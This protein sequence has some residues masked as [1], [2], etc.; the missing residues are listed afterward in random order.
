MKLQYT[1]TENEMQPR[2]KWTRDE[3]AKKVHQFK[4]DRGEVS[5]RQFAQQ[6]NIARTTLQH[7]LSRQSRM[8]AS[9]EAITFFESPAGVAFLHRL[10][11]A[12]HLMM[13]LVNPCGIEQVGTF[14]DLAGLGEF[15][16]TSYSA[17]Y[18]YSK[19][20]LK[21]LDTYD[22]EQRIELV[23]RL[24]DELKR[25]G[26]KAK[27]IILLEDETFHPEICL[28]A[29]EAASNFILVETYS[30]RRDAESWNDAV[31]LGLSGLPV[32]VVA[33]NADEGKGLK[34][35]IEKGLGVTHLC[36]LFHVQHEISKGTSATL[37]Q[38]T[39]AASDSLKKCQEAEDKLKKKKK[40]AKSE[41]VTSKLELQLREAACNVKN[42]QAH[43]QEMSHQQEEMREAVR[44]LSNS[45]HPYDLENGVK[46]SALQVQK[47]LE[48]C[49]DKAQR[50][51]DEA[52]LSQR[53]CKHIEK[54]KRL[55]EA[56][57]ATIA[58][59][60]TFV[61]NR[62]ASLNLDT[63]ISDCLNHILIPLN[64][65]YACARKATTADR[66]NMI[67][68]TIDEL[69]ERLAGVS[70]WQTL[71]ESQRVN[72]EA[73][74]QECATFF[75][76]SDSQV[77]GRN[78]QLSLHHHGIHRLNSDKLRGLTIIHNHFLRRRHDNTTAAE[79]FFGVPG[80]DLFEWLLYSM[81]LPPRPAQK[82]S[83][84]NSRKVL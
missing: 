80:E 61:T 23:K 38:R 7:W 26:N 71:S 32:E 14:L 5:Q 77:E 17:H 48:A 13:T 19:E 29:I 81:K 41:Q 73:F 67:K 22:D 70:A 51:A 84:I 50:V 75:V 58:F 27:P 31:E 8:S 74:A 72:L 1:S 52:G 62:T 37:G 25:Q 12:S 60:H 15:I 59:F 6:H 39:R 66:R 54:A 9:P 18:R 53:S 57:V 11:V 69:S 63:H 78:G 79:R 42:K 46:R 65:L 35:H 44:G 4:E 10:C 82:R 20:L 36:E 43:L 47:D 21:A 30:E 45:Y 3:V 33:V 55:K 83:R 28:V 2:K 24:K 68:K 16:A 34:A 64:Y 56:M 49:F 40:E 76:R